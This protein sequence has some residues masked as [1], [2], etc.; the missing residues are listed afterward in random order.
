LRTQAIV[1]IKSF[2][3]AKQR[4][5]GVL[6]A[7]SRR[8]L[9]QA[10]FADV[11]AALRRCDGIER[12]VVVT[13]DPVADS[14]ARGDGVPVLHDDASSGQSAA[15]QIGIADAIANGFDRVLLVPGDT[16]L[17]DPAEVD[18][19]LDRTARDGIEV[20]IVPDRHGTGTNALVLAP[21]DAMPPSFGEGSFERHLAAARD[22]GRSCRA[23]AVGSLAPDVD[24]PDDLATVWSMLDGARA[25]GQRTRGAL[26]QLD[27]SGA[28]A[29]LD[30]ARASETLE[31]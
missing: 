4:L 29:A 19:L 20:A 14:I 12:I 18:E 5:A 11:L 15:T 25:R 28:R 3:S 21:P 22:A 24:T 31:V 16:P 13:A 23:E 1:P 17:L 8:S 2:S 6:A 9:V 10:M 30:R 7:G 27:R 26:R